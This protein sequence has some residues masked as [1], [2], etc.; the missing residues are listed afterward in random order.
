MCSESVVLTDLETIILCGKS[1]RSRSLLCLRLV[2]FL[3]SVRLAGLIQI[4]L[5]TLN[6]SLFTFLTRKTLCD[7][8]YRQVS[9]PVKFSGFSVSN[10]HACLKLEC[11]SLFCISLALKGVSI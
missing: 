9:L 3:N 7:R 11:L 1:I 4:N 8:E 2:S 10:Q 5:V 6:G